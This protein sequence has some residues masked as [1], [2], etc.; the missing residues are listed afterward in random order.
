MRNDVRLTEVV[1]EGGS[2]V[3]GRP[4]IVD[5]QYSVTSQGRAI[6]EGPSLQAAELAFTQAVG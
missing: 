4:M 5:R 3:T 2:P 1:L 6:Y